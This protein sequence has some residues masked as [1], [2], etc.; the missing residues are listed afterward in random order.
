MSTYKKLRRRTEKERGKKMMR[1]RWREKR[2][3]TERGK[4]REVK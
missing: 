1:V 4:E 2:L 3:E